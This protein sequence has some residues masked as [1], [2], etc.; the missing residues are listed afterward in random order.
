[1]VQE[2]VLNSNAYSCV[3]QFSVEEIAITR[4]KKNITR[5][6]MSFDRVSGSRVLTIYISFNRTMLVTVRTHTHMCEKKKIL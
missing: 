3:E 2:F 6:S 4:R 5:I 1:M